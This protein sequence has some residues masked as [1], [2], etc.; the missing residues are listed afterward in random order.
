MSPTRFSLHLL[1][2]LRHVGP[3]HLIVRKNVDCTGSDAGVGLE[4]EMD[5]DGVDSGTEEEVVDVAASTP[6]G[7]EC[8][9]G[10]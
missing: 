8:A 2:Q 3:E 9:I 1:V 4:V 10:K 6:N 7:F 5:D